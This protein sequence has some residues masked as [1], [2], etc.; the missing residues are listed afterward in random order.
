M[1]LFARAARRLA[2]WV[3]AAAA[4]LGT[5][6]FAAAATPAQAIDSYIRSYADGGNF[7]GVV[8]VERDGKLLFERA[9]GYADRRRRVANT[10][11]TQFHI[12]SMSMQFTAAA[13]MRLV[14]RGELSLDTP[15]SAVVGSLPWGDRV[16]VRHLLMERSG[17][18]DIN[19]RD[20]YGDILQKAQTPRSLVTAVAGQ[21]LIFTPGEKFLHEEHS[22]YNLLALI[23]ETKAHRPFA[24]AVSDLVFRPL[25]M[26]EAAIDDDGPLRGAVATGHQPTG[27]YGI[28]P[29]SAI[30][31]SAKAGNA[32][33]VLSA[34]DEARWVR[35]LVSSGFLSPSS[36]D[37]VLSPA[38]RV[39]FGWF[40]SQSK[41]FGQ[42][43]YYM[44]GRAPGFA[45][46]VLYLP[47]E[48]LTVV[49]LSNIYSSST[50]PLGDD[51]A[52]LALGRPVEGFHPLV[53]KVAIAGAPL[54]FRFGGD[55]YQPNAVLRLVA[56]QD[57]WAL[58]WP[59]D[60]L[61][62]LIP[63]GPDRFVDRAYWQEVALQRDGQGRLTG[64]TYDRFTG[65]PVAEPKP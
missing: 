10:R 34:R 18:P 62:A 20:D 11:A 53:G 33:V 55:F 61:T 40:K 24:G 6:T 59:G 46:Y 43:A 25:G 22:A 15:A 8:R 35:A 27:V 57:G 37:A 31:W 38:E 13:V 4:C 26:T 29:A 41:R 36:R 30:H 7:S 50:T 63:V 3:L 42:P 21:P 1:T 12:A 51:V 28:E 56:D 52:A 9:Y 45:S 16:T 5:A 39:G 65:A 14:D 64:M 54:G 23:V 44:N 32:S 60:S 48:R 47:N 19:A 58:R 17:L 49:A 2:A